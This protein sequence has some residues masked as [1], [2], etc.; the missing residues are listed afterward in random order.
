MVLDTRTMRFSTVNLLTGYHV[1][2]RD[3]PDQSIV[4]GRRIAV[5]VGREGALELFSLICQHGSFALHH[6]TLQNNSQE[7]QLEKIIQLPGRYRGYSISTVGAAEGF[8]FFQG[9]PGEQLS[10]NVD[11]FSL[12]VKTYEI[13]KICTKMEQFFNRKRAL[14]YFSFPPLLSEPTI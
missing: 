4:H 1:Q 10:Q 8:L 2:L 6:T 9:A 12:E 5:V 13:T 7:W 11:C 14:P 3:L